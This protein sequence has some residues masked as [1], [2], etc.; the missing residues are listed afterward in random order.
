ML[1]KTVIAGMTSIVLGLGFSIA[2]PVTAA[3]AGSIDL[4]INSGD[5]HL[6][7]HNGPGIRYRHHT[8]RRNDYGV[9]HYPRQR[10]CRPGRALHKAERRGVR[11]ARIDRVGHRFVIVKGRKRG[12]KIKMAFYR[13]S[14][15]CELA[16]V[17]RKPHRIHY[18]YRY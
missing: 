17:K 11:H 15:R 5:G 9:R 3:N 16:W 14:N 12:G 18:G 8:Q 7:L 13:D 1:K 4:Y 2:A 10:I 6:R